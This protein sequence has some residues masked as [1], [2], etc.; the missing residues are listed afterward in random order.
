MVHRPMQQTVCTKQ[1]LDC[2]ITAYRVFCSRIYKLGGS[3]ILRETE[4][5]V[6]I[7][8]KTFAGKAFEPLVFIERSP[9]LFCTGHPVQAGCI[10]TRPHSTCLRFLFSDILISFT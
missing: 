3:Q 6:D 8:L 10:T 9:P 1:L 7:E 2:L 5:A 4:R